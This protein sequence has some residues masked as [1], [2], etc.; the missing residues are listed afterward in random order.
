VTL[1]RW[2]TAASPPAH[3]Q[4]LRHGE[5]TSEGRSERPTPLL[6]SQDIALLTDQD[7][8]AFHRNYRPLK[9][10][11]MD[12]R[13]YPLLTKRRTITPPPVA[14]LPPVTEDERRTTTPLTT[15]SPVEYDEELI[16]PEAIANRRHRS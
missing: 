2:S 10:R 6:A 9:L 11:R 14:K 15:K 13:D 12:W 4:T 5:E 16:N 7:V 1:A 8:I 3:S